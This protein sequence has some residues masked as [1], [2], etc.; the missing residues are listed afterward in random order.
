MTKEKVI[1]GYNLLCRI[2]E[3]EKF[4]ETLK[5]AERVSINIDYS[6]CKNANCIYKFTLYK[7]DMDDIKEMLAMF[8]KKLEALNRELAAL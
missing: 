4:V 8:T 1:D 2:E 6:K 3:L 5:E 7:D